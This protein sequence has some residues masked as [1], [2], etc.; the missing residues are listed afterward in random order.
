LVTVDDHSV[1]L[2]PARHML[3]VRNDDRP[4]M[5]GVVGSVIGRAGV[6][7]ADMD[8][9]QSPTGESA[10]MVLATSEPVPDAVQQELRDAA[11]IASVDAIDLG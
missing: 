10:L 4:G 11:G 9:G 2:P 8:V 5:I 3:V 6:N 7:I 1:D